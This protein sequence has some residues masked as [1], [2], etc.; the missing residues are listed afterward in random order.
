[1]PT[2]Y[3][4]DPEL[5]DEGDVS[6]RQSAE[7]ED[8]TTEVIQDKGKQRRRSHQPI[9]CTAGNLMDLM[10]MMLRYRTSKPQPKQHNVSLPL[11]PRGDSLRDE[12]RKY[13]EEVKYALDTKSVMTFDGTNYE[14]WR[15]RMLADAEVIGRTGII[16]RN[17]REST[18]TRPIEVDKWKVRSKALYRRMLSS[19][20]GNV[21]TTIGS[22]EA[23][24]AAAL[25]EKIDIEYA[26]SLAEERVNI[27]KELT[28]LQVRDSDYLAFQRRFRY[29]VARHKELCR[30]TQDIYHD[31]FLNGLRDYQKM[32]VKSRLDDFFSTGQELIVNI[33][34]DDLMNQLTNRSSKRVGS[35][36]KK[37]QLQAD[38]TTVK[39]DEDKDNDAKEKDKKDDDKKDNKDDKDDK[40][41]NLMA[42]QPSANAVII[43]GWILFTSTTPG[44]A[45][46]W[47][48]DMCASLNMTGEIH[49]FSSVNPFKGNVL[50][51]PA[52]EGVGRVEKIGNV[53]LEVDGGDIRLQDVHYVP[54]LTVNL[55]SFV[56]LE[57]QGFRFTLSST[58]PSFFICKAPNGVIFHAVRTS[59]NNIYEATE[60]KSNDD[61]HHPS[62]A[63][64]YMTTSYEY[65]FNRKVDFPVAAATTVANTATDVSLRPEKSKVSKT[66]LEWHNDLGHVHVGAI[67]AMA[68]IPIP[69]SR[70]K[71]LRPSFSARSALRRV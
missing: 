41:D 21:C 30:G 61:P 8:E 57:D 13:Q 58:I 33:D 68:G 54:N 17:Q 65:Y 59:R 39:K 60:R 22:L 40:N 49:S 11:P 62:R 63:V 14:A 6:F 55:L 44:G 20:I 53:I 37:Q 4:E 19:L 15:V 52:A 50:V 7:F 35:E 24:N 28:R 66:L 23:D 70:L 18:A 1:M 36:P 47:F 45:K 16:L 29:L 67:I 27:S 12:L 71:V 34:L 31:L 38:S 9:Y 69:E 32:F 2:H 64:N 43:K 56:K 10:Q 3:E 42:S 5:Q 51:D 25:W 26:I 46:P 48:L